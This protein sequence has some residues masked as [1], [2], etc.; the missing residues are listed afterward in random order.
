MKE[1]IT[2]HLQH[3]DYT[4]VALIDRLLLEIGIVELLFF[5]EIPSKVTINELI[6]IAKD[7]STD[8]SGKFVNGMLHALMTDL[9]ESGKLTKTGRGLIDHS[10]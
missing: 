2:K 8:E 10:H 9:T 5:E 7:F 3:W 4:R 1:L 6:E